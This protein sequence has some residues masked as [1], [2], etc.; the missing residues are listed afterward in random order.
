MHSHSETRNLGKT[1]VKKLFGPVK[2]GLAGWALLDTAVAGA[3]RVDT[4]TT[5]AAATA[6]RTA[7]TT[8]VA[9]AVAPAVTQG[10]DTGAQRI[11]LAVATLATTPLAT[12]LA[13][14]AAFTALARRVATGGVATR[15]IASRI[16][17]CP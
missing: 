2:P 9:V 11:G 13:A 14:T 16:T 8:T 3:Q 6:A 15:A 12:T 1:Y 10:V 7:A 5:I 17:D 4:A